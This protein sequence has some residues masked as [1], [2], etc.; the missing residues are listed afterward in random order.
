M[1][2]LSVVNLLS[3]PSS[4]GFD[5]RSCEAFGP[6]S[7]SEDSTRLHEAELFADKLNDSCLEAELAS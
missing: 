3:E 6:L 4:S 7:K 5:L 2:V 1:I